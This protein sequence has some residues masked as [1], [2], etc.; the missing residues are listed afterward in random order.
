M[1]YRSLAFLVAAAVLTLSGCPRFPQPASGTA[2]ADTAQSETL[3]TL[4]R[5]ESTAAVA[6]EPVAP[7]PEPAPEPLPQ[8]SQPKVLPRLWDFGSDN[9]LPCIE[10]GRILEPMMQEYAGRVEIR[11]INVYQNRELAMQARIQVIPTQIFYDAA[12]N[13]LFRHVGVYPRDSILAKFRQFG[14]E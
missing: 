13:E 6:V 1:M 14:W 2:A 12:G 9:C 3:A 10:M 11:I 8:P 5:Q 7:K 4:P